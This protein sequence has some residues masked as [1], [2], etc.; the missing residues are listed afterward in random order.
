MSQ[1]TKKPA[2][3]DPAAALRKEIV[4]TLKGPVCQRL[5][6]VIP[7]L[8]A[9]EDVYGTVMSSPELLFACLQLFH[10]MREPFQD[11]LVDS[12]GALVLTDDVAL[13]CGRSI[14]EIIGMIVR[15]GARAY[16]DR[17]FAPQAKAPAPTAT[18]T[19]LERL[20]KMVS[21]KWENDA[22]VPPKVGQ[23]TQADIF[24]AAIKD[25][26]DYDWQ[27][28]LIPHFAELPV[29][30]IAEMG[31]GVTT[32]RTPEAIHALANIGRR[33][34]EEARR[35]LSDDMMREMLD[36]QPLAAQGVA[37]LGKE[38]YEFLHSTVYE[39]MGEKFW[40]MCLDTGRLE[41]METRPAKELEQLAQYLHIISGETIQMMLEKFQ[42]WQLALFLDVGYQ[43]LGEETFTAIFG[44][45]GN[46]VIAK[47]FTDKVTFFKADKPGCEAEEFAD[48][49]P[50]VFG[51]YLR[52]PKGFEKG[53]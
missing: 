4:T 15:S 40:D 13:R 44:V 20:R 22:A 48:K 2:A 39:T 53:W 26:L 50:D 19:L 9:S 25:N 30:L 10:R 7:A 5:A 47:R 52:D 41:A 8:A 33:S 16:I 49:M 24:Y 29:K 18:P 37:F 35:I 38:K 11:L 32:L 46:P 43:K 34:M 42:F 3:A 28:P 23:L 21:S 31:K 6:K 1:P 27:V 14:D 36:T 17:R 51:A 45:P 12:T